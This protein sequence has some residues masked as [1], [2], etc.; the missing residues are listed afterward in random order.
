MR[1]WHSRRS[2]ACRALP[3]AVLSA[4]MDSIKLV[5]DFILHVDKHLLELASTYGS[6]VYAI[7]FGIV[8]METGLV[9]TP[10]LPGDSLLFAAGALAGAGALDVSIVVPLLI[11]AAVIGDNVNYAIGR[12]IGPRV[13]HEGNR[14]LKQEYLLRTH[15]F[16]EKHGGKTI[17]LARFVP[18]VRTFAPFVAGIGRM[19]Y[20]KFMAYNVAGGVLWVCFFC[21]LGYFFGGLPWVKEHFSVAVIA[22]IIL[23]LVPMVV[24]VWKARVRKPVSGD[25]RHG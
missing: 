3:D 6:W 24:E 25:R 17:V 12:R 14:F 2:G 18:I 19:E 7:L 1:A 8:F 16:Y 10:F 23:S 15:D 22:I 9:V 20:R 5:I 4:P 11:A 13:F 21:L